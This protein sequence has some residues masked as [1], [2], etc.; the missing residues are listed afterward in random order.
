M[1]PQ[2]VSFVVYFQYPVVNGLNECFCEHCNVCWHSEGACG[3]GE[4][5]RREVG[6][7][8]QILDHVLLGGGE[9]IL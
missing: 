5:W 9:D 1:F 6:Q 2:Y 3:N 7:V 8:G 4:S